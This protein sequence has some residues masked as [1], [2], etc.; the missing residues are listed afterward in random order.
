MRLIILA[1]PLLL[2][3]TRD[4]FDR[5]VDDFAGTI[6]AGGDETVSRFQKAA[7]TR[8][9]KIVIRDRA[10][11]AAEELRRRSERDAVPEYFKTRYEEVEG[12]YRL[13]KGQEEYRRRLLEENAAC[14]ADLEK[15]RPYFRD[16]AENLIDAPEI[17][18]RLKRIFSNP[19]NVDALY[20]GGIRQK[21][22]PDLYVILRK[23]G[24]IFAM[25]EDGRFYIPEGSRMRAGLYVKIGGVAL[26][27]SKSVS[28][29]LRK[30]GEDLA[31]FDDLHK[32]LKPAMGDPLFAGTL[33][34]KAFGKVDAEDI[35]GSV[36]RIRDAAGEMA[37][38]LPEVFE[39]TP[40]G[41]V[42]VERAY[43]EV[44][45]TLDEYDRARHKVGVLRDPGRQLAARLRDKDEPS[46]AFRKMLTSDVVLA[47]LDI[48]VSR[49]ESD[50]VLYI[51]AQI[52]KVLRKRDDGKYEVMPEM[53]EEV[54]R[55]MKDPAQSQAREERALR[56]VAMYGDKMHEKELR[57]IFTSTFGRFEVEKAMKEAL[58]VRPYDGLGAWIDRHFEK[59]AA[60]LKARP[61]SKGELEAVL[62]E[63]EKLEKEAKKNDLKD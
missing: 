8:P 39:P 50:P 54:G 31:P 5:R 42:L 7:K 13:R 20:L 60:G 24:E 15:I 37:S 25:A 59:T 27:G 18:A 19:N 6:L 48:D 2:M 62:A 38:R 46:E 53:A 1:L 10:E 21:T 26:E 32:R 45:K 41:K 17:N 56:I 63:A 4:D 23:M 55:E 36:Q 49:E 61:G 51:T 29:V 47:L 9:G 11:K 14:K 44:G 57:E 16:L 22:R 28:D 58:S 3:S 33:L 12:T 52:K 43:E 34:R 40:K 30:L 35:D